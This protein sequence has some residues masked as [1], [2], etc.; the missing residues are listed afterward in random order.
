M[1]VSTGYLKA[2]ILAVKLNGKGN[3]TDSH[4]TWRDHRGVPRLSSPIVVDKHL[5]MVDDGG[6]L[7]CRELLT[8][9]TLWRQRLNAKYYASPVYAAGRIYLFDQNGKAHVIKPGPSFESLATNSLAEGCMA[10][11]AVV[12][13][14]LIV[15]TPSYMYRIQD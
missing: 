15:R 10:S 5:Y 11:P 6:F 4:I 12:E 7:S 2:D 14:A 3:V 13:G 9:K 1:F 8:G